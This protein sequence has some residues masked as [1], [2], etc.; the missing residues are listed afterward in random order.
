MRNQ[1]TVQGV[2]LEKLANLQYKVQKQD[3]KVIRCY[4]AGK[5][6]Q[7]KI[8]VEVHDDVKLV[9]DQYGNIGRIVW[10][11]QVSYGK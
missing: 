10:R 5:L 6:K 3:G 11:K 4:L 7:N 9:E 2:V 1:D 8:K